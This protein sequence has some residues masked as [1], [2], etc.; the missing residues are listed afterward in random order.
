MGGGGGGG[1][2]ESLTQANFL[3]FVLLLFSEREEK[4]SVINI[5]L[6]KRLMEVQESLDKINKQL[7]EKEKAC[8]QEKENLSREITTLKRNITFTNAELQNVVSQIDEL[9]AV[10]KNNK[11]TVLEIGT[12]LN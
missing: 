10:L 12:Q 5:S 4:L 6:E 9:M 1:R 7:Q 2:G 11:G 8:N 3:S